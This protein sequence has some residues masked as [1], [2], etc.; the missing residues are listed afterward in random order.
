MT[1]R[2]IESKDLEELTYLRTLM[3]ENVLT[4]EDLIQIGITVE[5][6]TIKLQTTF[7]GWLC[8]M[9]NKTV[10]FSMGNQEDGEM[11]VVAVHPDYEKKGV[12]K[13]VITL[14]QNWLFQTN[15]TLWLTREDKPSNRA[16]GFYEKL[17]WNKVSTD[18][19]HCRF[20][21]EKK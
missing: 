21:L 17:G 11:W 2:E 13:K 14:V 3:K 8:E 5:E 19:K 15:D 16:Y 10:G 20:E 12:D 18:N 9:D 4:M 7:K 1:I 6:T